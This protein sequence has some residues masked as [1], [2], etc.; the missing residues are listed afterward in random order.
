MKRILRKAL[1][2]IEEV[3]KLYTTVKKQALYTAPNG[4]PTRLSPENWLLVR[5]PSFKA[6]FGDW[7][8]DSENSSKVIDENGE[9]LL[10]Y[11]GSPNLFEKFAKSSNKKFGI[12]QDFGDFHWFSECRDTA[13][14]YRASNDEKIGPIYEC[15]L[16]IRT[17][18][19][20]EKPADNMKEALG[21]D[22]F[23]DESKDGL[24][25]HNVCDAAVSP[26]LN[27]V[28]QKSLRNHRLCG[29]SDDRDLSRSEYFALSVEERENY[30]VYFYAK[31][32]D[33]RTTPYA[34]SEQ[35]YFAL[36]KR[37]RKKYELRSSSLYATR[38]SN[39]RAAHTSFAVLSDDQILITYVDIAK[40]YD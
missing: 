20:S 35:Q 25:V 8:T 37:D 1:G 23:N 15:F 28:Y 21:V 27:R 36:P 4:K 6:W 38:K 7:E 17:P 31:S 24:I 5:T 34:L 13:C 33:R 19:I 14:T 39:A 16:N 30:D 12:Y 29:F 18:L 10:V 2:E 40:E 3:R 22:Q 11:H 26:H 32:I 9:P